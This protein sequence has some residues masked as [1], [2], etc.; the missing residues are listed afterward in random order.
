M[1]LI[2]SHCQKLPTSPGIYQM[3]D[4]SGNI[5]Y[6]GKTK[7]LRKRVSS[8]FNRKPADIKTQLLVQKIDHIKTILTASENEAFILENQLIKQ[9]QPKYNMMLKDD[10]N[11]PYIKITTN[12]P[13]PRIEF[14][15]QKLKETTRHKS[16]YFGPFPSLGSIAKIKKTL[17]ELFQIRMCTQPIHLTKPQKKCIYVDIHRCLGPCIHKNLKSRYDQNI[18]ELILFLSGKRSKLLQK[19]TTEMNQK[20]NNLE[21]EQAILIRDRIQKLKM[22]TEK[23]TVCLSEEKNIHVWADAENDQYYYAIVLTILEGKLLSQRGF[24][25][26]KTECLN[27]NFLLNCLLTCYEN[28]KDITDLILCTKNFLEPLEELKKAIQSSKNLN[29]NF[30][31]TGDKKRLL[32]MAINNA[33]FALNRILNLPSLSL[34]TQESSLKELQ[35]IFHFKTLPITIM[36]VDI[37][38]LSSEN[39]VGATIVFQ[40]AKPNKKDYRLFNIRSV[41]NKNN[42]PQAIYETVLRSISQART[43]NRLPNLLLI[44]GG[45]AQLNFAYQALQ[46]LGLTE[47]EILSLAKKN[48]EIY[49]LNKKKPIILQKNSIVLHLLQQIRDEAHRFVVSAQRKKRKQVFIKSQ[50]YQIKGLG[51]KKISLLLKHFKTI[52]RIK[53]ASPKELSKAGISQNLATLI[54][55]TIK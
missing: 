36:G 12:E 44:D 6:I 53:N 54:Q 41:Q 52:D 30:P 28:Q 47:I 45:K 25:I 9:F 29:Y 49:S 17:Q 43:E 27:K 33:K 7:N 11:F 8:Y 37:S 16:R 23:Q 19:L 55:K 24:Y 35:N 20:V 34:E 51:E 21:F 39:M 18:E 3:L 31:Q 4:H 15:R 2:E 48:E 38:H 26:H 22:L 32:E 1:D 42:D 14:I 5:I 10:K 13:F 40:F 46:E 50:L